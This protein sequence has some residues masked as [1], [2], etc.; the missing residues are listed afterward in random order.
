MVNG[1]ISNNATPLLIN[2][3]T[4]A[5][6]ICPFIIFM[7]EICSCC[8]LQSFTECL[9]SRWLSV[10]VCLFSRLYSNFFFLPF[11]SFDGIW[12]R[13]TISSKVTLTNAYI[14]GNL[15]MNCALIITHHSTPKKL[16]KTDRKYA[17]KI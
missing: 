6:R 13:K 15:M 9:E 8:S 12:I 14:K 17:K 7:G 16:L 2:P 3:F 1:G 11:L 4:H 5:C 10:E